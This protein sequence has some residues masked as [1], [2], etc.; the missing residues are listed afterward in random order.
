M[1]P[2][3]SRAEYMRELSD[4]VSHRLVPEDIQG[5]VDVPL[6]GELFYDSPEHR[7][8]I[9]EY[10]A[11]YSRAVE[12]GRILKPRINGA[13]PTV[14]CDRLE[15]DLTLINIVLRTVRQNIDVYRSRAKSNSA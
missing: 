3:K 4:A 14:S 12:E 11:E 6:I 8:K 13:M 1:E 15:G 5:T 7:D 2:S 10:S 9:L